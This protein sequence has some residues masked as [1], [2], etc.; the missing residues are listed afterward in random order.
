MANT[1]NSESLVIIPTY[2]E[3]SNLKRLLPMLM[4]LE[5]EIDVLFV[6]D[7]SPDGT[8]EVIKRF[9]E[10]YTGRIHLISRA[11][12][13]GLGS[14]YVAG[15][16]FALESDY[17]YICEM[18]AD[19]SH[20]P[21]DLPLLIEEARTQPPALI[22]GSRYHNGISIVNWPL[23]RLILSY[24]ANV[25][26]RII[27]G[28]PVFDT[29]AG[30][31]CFHRKVL[32]A[33]PLERIKSNGY[34]FQIE[35]HYRAWKAGFNLKEVSIIFREREEGESKMSKNIIFEA[36]WMVWALKLRSL[37]NRL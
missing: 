19:F 14:A 37:I 2:N 8:Q 12:K 3:A 13:S 1:M 10:E 33:I 26:A 31:K 21:G 5:P 35:M 29:T 15:F 24:S 17:T 9:Q 20:D 16:K 32:E 34:A 7:N 36:V 25:Y 22:I 18:D 4:Q 28:L 6:D 27:T 23:S 30:F 11:S